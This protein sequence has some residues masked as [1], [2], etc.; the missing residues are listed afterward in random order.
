MNDIWH[1]GVTAHHQLPFS[2]VHFLNTLI[3]LSVNVSKIKSTLLIK[4][5]ML[6]LFG[7]PTTKLLSKRLIANWLG[8]SES[9]LIASTESSNF[10][11]HRSHLQTLA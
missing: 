4:S 8:G 6:G 1:A 5:K 3:K 7:L 9:G 2:S 11:F 10:F